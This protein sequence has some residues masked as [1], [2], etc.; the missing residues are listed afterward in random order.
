MKNTRGVKTVTRGCRKGDQFLFIFEDIITRYVQLLITKSYVRLVKDHFRRLFTA[1]F[2]L[3]LFHKF[4]AW[5][6]IADAGEPTTQI[7]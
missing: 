4:G 1:I 5:N 3:I 7:P 6:A 2:A